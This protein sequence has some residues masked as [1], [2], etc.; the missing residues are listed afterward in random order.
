MKRV[1]DLNALS[2]P[3][4]FG[5][6]VKA[7]TLEQLVRAALDED[8]GERGD[9]TSASIIESQARGRAELAVRQPG[10]ICGQS[11][12]GAILSNFNADALVEWRKCDGQSCDRG[13]VIA[14]FDGRLR[15]LLAIER[16]LLN[17]I[18][19]LSGIASLTRRYVQAVA[20][21]KAVICDTRKTTPGWRGLEKYAVRCGGGVLHRLGLHDA[22]LYKDNHLA[23]IEPSRMTETLERAARQV[24]AGGAIRFVEVEADSLETFERVLAVPQGLLDIVLL[25]NLSVEQM[26]E[27]VEIRDRRAPR[28]LLEASGGVTLETVRAIAET[29]VD[30]ISVG[31]I[32][33]SAPALDLALD[34]MESGRSV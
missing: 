7:E 25:D 10:V 6:L 1:I 22:A 23:H 9:I 4:L 16:T 24:R 11:V 15:D 26:R 34:M 18:G 17:F 21:T 5:R 8:F 32:T 30:R 20:G 2:L 13:D 28:M 27:A 29:G 33:H 31:A 12:A 19:H 3:E 14:A